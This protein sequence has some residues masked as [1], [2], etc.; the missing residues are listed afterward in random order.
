MYNN[1]ISPEPDPE[2]PRIRSGSADLSIH[3]SLGSFTA[4]NSDKTDTGQRSLQ[5]ER[6][7]QGQSQND[8]K[9]N[10]GSGMSQH[11]EEKPGGESEKHVGG[12]SWEQNLNRSNDP[13]NN[14]GDM[15]LAP[16]DYREIDNNSRLSDIDD[17]TALILPDESVIYKDKKSHLDSPKVTLAVKKQLNEETELFEMQTTDSSLQRETEKKMYLEAAEKK[18]QPESDL[19]H[20][21]HGD[22][23]EKTSYHEVIIGGMLCLV[24]LSC[25]TQKY[26]QGHAKEIFSSMNLLLLL[27]LKSRGK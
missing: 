24:I 23:K 22:I 9:Q 17:K 18:T 15:E 16:G 14:S 26:T 10:Q 1:R 5:G 13:G 4:G 6:S 21:R 25:C 20:R 12:I 19:R 27:F 2:Q 3:S 7:L 8:T 11:S